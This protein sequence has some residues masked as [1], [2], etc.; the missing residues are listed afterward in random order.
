MKGEFECVYLYPVN[1]FSK[2]LYAI[3]VNFF[4]INQFELARYELRYRL[5]SLMNLIHTTSGSKILNK[6][7]NFGSTQKGGPFAI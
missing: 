5:T 6:L 4:L 2:N 7:L 3:V 1:N